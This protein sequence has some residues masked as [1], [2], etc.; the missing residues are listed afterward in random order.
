MFSKLFWRKNGWIFTHPIRF[1]AVL[2]LI[3]SSLTFPAQSVIADDTTPPELTITGA[4]ADGT[5]M[6]GDLATGYILE[7]RRNPADEWLI[8][9]AAGTLTNELLADT[10]FGLTLIDSTVNATDLKAYYDARG[11]PE[12]YLTYL[13]DAVDRDEPFVYIKGS[14]DLSVSLVDAAKHELSL[15]D[16]AMTVPDDF[17][18]GTYTVQGDITDVAGN[19]TTVTLILI[20]D[21]DPI[22]I[23]GN[24]GIDGATLSYDDGGPK[25]ET[26]TGGGHYS[27][28]VPYGWSGTVTPSKDHYSFDDPYTT[29]TNVID[30]INNQDYSASLIVNSPPVI[31]E[32]DPAP[33][34]MSEDG[35]PTAFNLTLHASDI[36]GDTLTW[37]I[38]T[39]GTN[40]NATVSGTGTEKAIGYAPDAN[41]FG[42]DSFV[43]Q[44]DDGWEGTDTITI[45]VTIESV[46]DVPVAVND[47]YSTP[48]DTTRNVDDPGVLTNDTDA[49]VLDTLTAV[50]QTDPSHGSVTLNDNGSFSYTPTGGY[51]G[52]DSFTY[53]AYDGTA[54]SDAATVTITVSAVNHNPTDIQLSNSSVAENL[55]SGTL[56]GALT[57]TDPDSG[58][59]TFTY[60]LVD[61]AG[62]PDNTSFSIDGSN[63]LTAA[64]F[65][66]E[67][68]ASYSIRIRT[69]D[70]GSPNLSY[71][72]VFTISVT[73]VNE[74]PTD[75]T[76]APATIAENLA[77]NTVVGALTTTDPD[78]GNTF[79]YSLVTGTGDTNNSSF[80]ISGSNLQT[81][82]IFNYEAKSSYSIRVR[83][84]TDQGGATFEKAFTI[85][86]TN[87]N[88]P[89]VINE[90]DS[91]GVVMGEDN[92]PPFS[93]TL[94]ATDEDIPANTLT[95]SINT[96]AA[97]G[98]ASI[99]AP[100]TGSSKA[101]TYTAD[102]NYNGSVFFIVQV[103]D[104]LVID[105]ITVN[106]TINPDLGDIYYVD[107]TI[108]SDLN[109]GLTPATAFLTI[110]KGASKARPGD[111]V[112]VLAGTFAE[113]VKPSFSGLD[114]Y[115]IT[116]TASPGVIVTGE[117]GN[118]DNGGAFR[119]SGF[120]YIVIN[121]FTIQ[122]TA[123]YG[124]YALNSSYLTITNNRVT[125]AGTP[126]AVNRFGIYILT[127][128]NSV[129]SGNT[130][131][132]NSDN[133]IELLNGSTNNTVSNNISY[134]NAK[135]TVSQAVGIEC[136]NSSNNTVIHNIVYANEDSG[137]NFYAGSSSNIVVGNLSYGN[138]D[139]GIDHNGA[140]NN[141]IVGNTVHGNVT[142]GINLE[143]S[144]SG[145]TL[146]NNIA[147]DNG[148]Q[149]QVGGGTVPG[150]KPGNIYVDST[151]VSGTTMNYDLVYLSTGTVQIWWG[152]NSYT[153]LAA[154][155][156]A[157][158]TLEVNGLEANPLLQSPAAIA[159]RP[160]GAPYNMTV[161]IGDYHILSGSPAID[162]ANS[163][164]SNE[165]ET[166]IAG[167]ARYD[168]PFTTNTGTGIRAYDDRG[169][170]EFE[171]TA[172]LQLDVSKNGTG[173]GTVTS[174]PSGVNCGADCSET[175]SYG[176][177]V[178]L[179]ATP[180]VGYYNR[181][182][183]WSGTGISCPGTGTCSVTMNAAK[184]VT[185]TFEKTT[186]GD[187]PFT[188]PRWAYIE[189][190]YDAGLTAGCQAA[191]QPLAFC[192]EAT[193]IRVES[194]V[195]MVRGELGAI[196]TPTDTAPDVFGDDFSAITWGKPWA[197]KMWD[198]GMTAGCQWPA[199]SVPKLFCPY[200]LFTRDMGAVFTL[201]MAHGA[202]M[203][204][205]VGKGTVFADMTDPNYWGTG[206]A[207]QAYAEGLLPDC[208]IDSV[209]GKPLFCPSSELSRS[210][211]AYTIVKA[212]DI[213]LPQ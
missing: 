103:S 42:S 127:T 94:S 202:S 8:Q 181:F 180:T 198:L 49:D 205:P 33:V 173:T 50:K 20:V 155:K 140:P 201:R 141:I 81:S 177:V 85:T 138:G 144:S 19:H 107:Q 165:A 147:M 204:I 59:T 48:Q 35:T 154:F 54:Y 3:F 136:R 114:G 118:A 108:G 43:V 110:G 132:H 23:S 75:I 161:N 178:I 113:T 79:T 124:I 60:A 36:D 34:T 159:V 77:I 190:L 185:A 61:N 191:G 18:L 189:A 174:S 101:I 169:A 12:P 175:Y 9:F 78:P 149:R 70:A 98:H 211:S 109:N 56:V 156:V 65:N 150:T 2:F 170:Y 164:A 139:H 188:H 39:D 21:I 5:A 193:M 91:I 22:T 76:L 53:K 120:S 27:I 63:L 184:T 112:M 32:S 30:N 195:F 106:V 119:M 58:D 73:D 97:H 1:F 196:P 210:W 167:M 187:V 182:T 194:A 52:D 96:Q 197:E 100:A 152:S 137:L 208:G 117:A 172:I 88:D 199:E 207:E 122:N 130:V 55:A 4:T 200:T 74:P 57:S 111:T 46:N 87:V 128:T 123:D 135:E 44:V 16:V 6:T 7:T 40:G 71:E 93:L 166:D 95:W 51:T 163:N 83:T 82:E 148:L 116:F 28:T 203:P 209:S 15:T 126:G 84:T 151:S 41:Y 125:S 17:P 10:Y 14:A 45:N 143:A 157:H 29:Y 171:P 146:A 24:A 72:E 145:A 129:I 13:K 162:S 142:S 192:P 25:T 90:G 104:G 121:G 47:S 133:G 11:I 62:Y 86:V 89:P 131:D 66:Y 179:T 160:A 206:W 67:T 92:T 168:D 31:T 213:P 153:S 158:P 38:L 105:T 134:A 80:N 26:S 176:T 186:F 212:K 115:P 37:S 99:V 183:G 102:A 68:K 69:T 64:V